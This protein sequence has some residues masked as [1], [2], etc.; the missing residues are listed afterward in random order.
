MWRWF[1]VVVILGAAVGCGKWKVSIGGGLPNTLYVNATSGDDA[2]DGTSPNRAKKTIQAALDAAKDGYTIIVA[3]GLYFGL[4][5]T[6]LCFTGKAVHL[7]SENGPANCIID[8]MMGGTRAFYFNYNETPNTIGEGLTIRF[9]AGSIIGTAAYI[10]Q[11]CSPSFVNCVFSQNTAVTSSV[12]YINQGSPSFSNCTFSNNS[13]SS[14]G[15]VIRLEGG[16]L[17]LSGCT[18]SENGTDNG[19][20]GVIYSSGSTISIDSCSF[21]NNSASGEGGAIYTSGTT[22][23]ISNT[24]F[25][26][27]ISTDWQGGALYVTSD[28]SLT[29]TNCTFTSNS[30]KYNGGAVYCREN[31]PLTAT[32][33]TFQ[34]NSAG[35]SG[36]AVFCYDECTATVTN[37]TFDSN[38]SGDEGGALRVEDLTSG[39]IA[40][41]GCSF[42]NNEVQNNHSGGALDLHDT[43]CDTITITACI[44]A[45]NHATH[46][47]GAVFLWSVGSSETTFLNCLFYKNTADYRGAYLSHWTDNVKF[48]NCTFADN[49]SNISNSDKGHTFC[50]LWNSKIYLYNCI[51][52]G[53][54]DQFYIGS[55]SGGEAYN[56]DVLDLPSG[57]DVSSTCIEQNPL[58]TDA[59]N[60]DY[61]LQA[62][63]PCI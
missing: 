3:D 53:D 13:S 28:G 20:G 59:A 52:W 29:V 21:E 10:G 19:R 8:C 55:G 36:G 12:I 7:R 23:S 22:V 18:F 46:D 24:S 5:N 31:T 9:C 63:S 61:T 39:D 62:S 49:E 44:F 32:G 11:N 30:C 6:N 4:D 48:I 16:S 47:G 38:T 14:D 33:C 45:N 54:G 15:G 26:G 40:I 25:T 41:T 17:T 1:V 35:E 34:S 58:F 50:L 27:N 42:L 43:D 2:Y 56:S 57:W 51:V 60:D 37:C